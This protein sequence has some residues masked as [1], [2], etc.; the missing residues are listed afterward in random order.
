MA[1]Y[2]YFPEPDI[3][4]LDLK[5]LTDEIRRTLPELPAHRRRR[6]V[7]E[8]G[9]RMEDARQMIDDPALANFTEYVMSELG[10]WIEAQE[11]I[12]RD[13]VA[14]VQRKMAKLVASWILNK[15]MGLMMERGIDIRTAKVSPENFAELMQMIASNKVTGTKALEVLGKMLEDGGDPSQIVEEMG[16]GRLDDVTALAQ[17]VDDVIAS[18]AKE[19]ERYKAGETK[20]LPFFIGQVMKISR[21]NADP[22]ATAQMLGEKLNG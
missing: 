11:N 19:V 6:F 7:D 10:G 5:D 18:N 21:G 13:D 1:D 9:F 16:A 2:R 22:D 3:P 12:D 8:Y 4:P 14:A 17:I 20:L 15:L